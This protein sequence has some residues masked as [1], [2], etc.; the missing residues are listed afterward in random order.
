MNIV[1]ESIVKMWMSLTVCV[2]HPLLLWE[3][4]KDLTSTDNDSDNALE[5]LSCADIC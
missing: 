2:K 3:V 5:V 4:F 1:V